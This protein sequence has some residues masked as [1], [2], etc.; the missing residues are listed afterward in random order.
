MTV[1]EANDTNTLLQWI[2]GIRQPGDVDV[3]DQELAD[4]AEKAAARLADR[5]RLQQPAGL[6]GDAVHDGWAA[7]EAC[8]WR[9]TS[10]A[11]SEACR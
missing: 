9:D 10:P 4:E 11:A 8:P 2:L 6:T 5:A 1:T 3:D 7:V